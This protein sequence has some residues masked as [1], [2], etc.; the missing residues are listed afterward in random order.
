MDIS[1]RLDSRFGKVVFSFWSALLLLLI[2]LVNVEFRFIIPF[3][4][5]LIANIQFLIGLIILVRITILYKRVY[6][7][8][9]KMVLKPLFGSKEM[10]FS[11]S[12]ISIRKSSFMGISNPFRKT[13]IVLKSGQKFYFFPSLHVPHLPS[14]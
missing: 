10:V 3:D 5:W 8:S 14:D 2:F 13:I 6:K 11:K 12:D 9:S 4:L 1:K 7:Y